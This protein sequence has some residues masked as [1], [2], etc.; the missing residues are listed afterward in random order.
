MSQSPAA[1]SRTSAG[2]LI[3]NLPIRIRVMGSTLV[4]LLLLTILFASYFPARQQRSSE[5]ELRERTSQMAEM[6][7]TGVGVGLE[8]NQLPTVLAVVNWAKRN[9]SL[10]YVAVLDTDGQSIGTYNPGNLPIDYGRINRPN[11]VFQSESLVEVATPV[12]YQERRLGTVF[13]GLSLDLTRQAANQFRVTALGLAAV[14][15]IL[16]A[17]LALVLADR[18]TEPIR[19]LRRISDEV[20]AGNYGVD[21]VV[22]GSDEVARLG[23]AFALMVAKIRQSVAALEANSNSLAEAR[24]HALAAARAKADFLAAMSHEIRTPMNG[25]L[26]MLGLLGD[27]ELTAKQGDYLRTASRSAQALL[28]VIDDILDFSKIEAGRVELERIDF[29]LRAT[30]EDA[31][32]LLAER[33]HG[34]GLDLTCAIDPAVPDWVVGD[35]V[36]IGQVLLN[37]GGNAV[38]FTSHGE[39]RIRLSLDQAFPDKVGIRFEISDTGIGMPKSVQNRLFEPFVQA[40]SSTTR[41][42]GGTGLG[43]S[44]SRRLVT[45]MDGTI[46]V[47]SDEGAGSTFWF[48]LELPRAAPPAEASPAPDLTGLSV[49][50]VDDHDI[51]RQ[52]L[53]QYLTPR[54]LRVLVAESADQARLV[55]D[56]LVPEARPVI[57]IIDAM[58]PGED[59]ASLAQSL[60]GDPRYRDMRLILVTSIGRRN[61]GEANQD[62]RFDGQLTKPLRLG[63]LLDTIGEVTGRAKA[64]NRPEP[65][66]PARSAPGRPGRLLL[67]EDHEINQLLALEILQRAGHQVDIVAN[68]REAIAARFAQPYDLILMD[69]QM[70]VIDGFAAT[71]AI[72]ARE[73]NKT[74]PIPIVAL[75]ANAIGGDREA[76]IE[77]GMDDYLS[78]PFT[79]NGLLSM[80]AKW[81][82]ST[83]NPGVGNG[84]PAPSR[85]AEASQPAPSVAA[86]PAPIEIAQLSDLVGGDPAKIKRYLEMFAK[87]T[88]PAIQDLGRAVASGDSEQ[89]RRLAHK[90]KGSCGMVGARPLAAVAAQLEHRAAAGE[91]AALPSLLDSLEAGF[92]T[93]RTFAARY[94]E[95]AP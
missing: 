87:L 12:I 83:P 67:A 5:N 40:D 79:P 26:G 34:K 58:M 44:I 66:G 68:G 73:A 29:D 42:F 18:I 54:G 16:G 91:L 61:E 53:E 47:E 57:G 4:V 64:S 1:V 62:G 94:Q 77:A 92:N 70:P 24:D 50:V 78:K 6:L 69:C 20:A 25:V 55:L 22:T 81:L 2:W 59:G 90:V 35:S 36:R 56:Q 60:R 52:V 19:R 41:R 80:I 43:L 72:R 76:C 85:P 27:T 89:V 37:L 28:T 84:D 75:T 14:A 65:V 86:E 23:Q 30:V 71:R 7:A 31:A 11:E 63:R 93:A 13:L 46:G 10:A 45:I 32:Q 51:N 21:I 74:A 38:K 88:E 8:L 15:L 33:A 9:K 82:P 17:T 49:L 48:A 3:G 95:V 39:V